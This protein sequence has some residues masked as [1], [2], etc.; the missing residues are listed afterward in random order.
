MRLIYLRI[1]GF[2]PHADTKIDFTQLAN[3]IAYLAPYGTGK[4]F[5]FEAPIACLW[6]SFIWYQGSIYDALTQGGNGHGEIELTFEQGGEFYTALRDVRDSGKTKTQ[7]CLLCKGSIR[8][9]FAE[10]VTLIAGPNV[11]DFQTFID[12]MI[13]NFDAVKATSVLGQN[14]EGDLCGQPGEANLAARRRNVMF[15]LIG[16]S[17]LDR[18]AELAADALNKAKGRMNVLEVQLAGDE[19]PVKE[20][21]LTAGR[22]HVAEQDLAAARKCL[23]TARAQLET[24]RGMIRDTQGGEDVLKEQ[25]AAYDAKMDDVFWLSSDVDDK[26]EKAEALRHRF[27]SIETERANVARLETLTGDREVL[28]EADAKYK[29]WI[30]WKAEA[31]R[32]Q[33]NV[34]RTRDILTEG[35][36]SPA[37]SFETRALAVR[38]G[39][40]ERQGI[41]AKAENEAKEFLNKEV[42]TKLHSL[43]ERSAVI[44]MRIMDIDKRL[45]AKP[46]TPF[47]DKCDDCPFLADYKNM[48]GDRNVLEKEDAEISALIKA[49]PDPA[50]LADL[51][52]LRAEYEQAKA[53]GEAVE[54][55]DWYIKSN[56]TM[57]VLLNEQ[58]SALADLNA[59]AVDPCD[60][61]TETIN[62]TQTDIDTLAGASD[63]LDAC[64]TAQVD[65]GAMAD[66][67]AEAEKTLS[68]R[69]AE[70]ATLRIT[71][72]S[73]KA[74]LADR[75]T[76]RKALTAAE[77]ERAQSVKTLSNEA[78]ALTGIVAKHTARIDELDRRLKVQKARVLELHD[79][80]PKVE[81]LADNRAC[82]GPNG[83]R[84]ILIDDAAPELEAIADEL[85]DQATGGRMRLRIATQKVNADGT[86]AEDFKILIRDRV[87]ERDALRY[88]GGQLQL[89]LII[90]R[91][92]VALWSSRLRGKVAESLF[93]DEACDRLGDEGTEDLL[94]VFAHLKDRFQQIIIVT[95]DQAIAERMQSHVLLTA[96]IGGV[97]VETRGD[98]T[99]ITA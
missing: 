12:N 70:A 38:L 67:I 91:I 52:E 71:A 85:F 10:N 55:A 3:Q 93:L 25:I 2:G 89:I 27:A 64:R 53:A 57:R 66:Q 81:A 29:A 50:P 63:R 90:F 9:P 48:P 92:S 11:R 32:L 15:D 44:R 49:V 68:T 6:G 78:D 21:E 59:A 86:L 42:R 22:L 58:R 73:A 19:D 14:R 82:W 79:L 45:A 24:A 51:A 13:G 80:K 62:K 33:E 65:Y 69:E 47:G 97:T 96:G 77:A 5:L 56:D 75:E 43:T 74:A 46:E 34:D 4:T 37:V 41:K 30:E 88:S 23:E 95:H 28:R 84:Q 8:N 16:A 61:P 17:D 1:I 18:L 94:R 36:A 83:V 20:L 99:R 39:E 98:K 72:D 54:T 60:D 7:K 35:E 76:Q 26:R 40:I 87:G 31:T